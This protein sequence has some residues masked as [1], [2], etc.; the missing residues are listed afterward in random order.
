[1]TVSCASKLP[2][3]FLQSDIITL[4]ELA[5]MWNQQMLNTSRDLYD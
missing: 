2:R 4:F 5:Y 1:M 3:I